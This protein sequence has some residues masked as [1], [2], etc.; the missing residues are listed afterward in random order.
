MYAQLVMFTIGPGMRAESEQMADKFNLAHKNLKGFKNATFLGDHSIGEYSSL[1]IWETLEDLQ[2]AS[3]ILRPK[4]QEALSG[5][6]KGAP[7]VRIFEVYEP[8]D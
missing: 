3:D 2:A 8:K 6:A 1:T 4:L 5:I 7:T